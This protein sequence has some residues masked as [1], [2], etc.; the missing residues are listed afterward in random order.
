MEKI[1]E[2]SIQMK[3]SLT[4]QFAAMEKAGFMVTHTLTTESK[5]LF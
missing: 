4:Q 1:S 2:S 5:L 3:L